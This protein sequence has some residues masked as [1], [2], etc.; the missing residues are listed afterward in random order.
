MD[1]AIGVAPL[2]GLGELV[3]VASRLLRSN[4]M[5]LLLQQLKHVL[6]NIAKLESNA[7][8][9]SRVDNK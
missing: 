3:D 9:L 7:T 1:D 4:T 2:N 6:K 8:L 5:W